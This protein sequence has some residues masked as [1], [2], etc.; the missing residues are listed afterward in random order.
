MAATW[1]IVGLGNPGPEYEGNRHN[2]GFM[3]LDELRRRAGAGSPR[4]KFGGELSEGTVAGAKAILLKPME[5][6]NVS[7]EATGRTAQFYKIAP[8]ACVVVHDELDLPFARL[9]L[10][11]GGGAGG[12]NGLKSLI[13]HLGADFRRVRVG[14]GRP[15]PGRDAAAYVLADFSKEERKELPFLV[16]EAADAVEAILRDGL[17]AAMNKFNTQ[18]KV[19]A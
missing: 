19:G 17:P 14:I 16:G 10:G 7:G 12:H 15:A 5:F 4:L 6:M 8:D 3:V 1:L 2:V 9:K 18:K 13:S 11:A